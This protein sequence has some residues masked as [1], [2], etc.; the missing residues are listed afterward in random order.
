M[1]V[2]QTNA[3]CCDVLRGPLG[4]RVY[5]VKVRTS[6]GQCAC[7]LINEDSPSKAPAKV[8]KSCQNY[9]EKVSPAPHDTALCLAYGNVIP[10][11]KELYLVYFGWMLNSKLLLGKTE[12]EHVSC[13]ISTTWSVGQLRELVEGLLD[14]DKCAI[15]YSQKLG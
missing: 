4:D 9:G 3:D 12:V 13:I 15:D 10:D 5:H 7:D 1:A 6:L 11:D 2:L 14:N 8:N